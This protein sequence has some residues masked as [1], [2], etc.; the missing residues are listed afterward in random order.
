MEDLSAKLL[1]GLRDNWKI[2]PG[3]LKS[4]CKAQRFG[5]PSQ[6]RLDVR[7]RA[8]T[9]AGGL[10][11]RKHLISLEIF[12]TTVEPEPPAAGGGVRLAVAV[13]TPARGYR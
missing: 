3:R 5:S 8:R 7:W 9:G 12:R 10:A 11:G 4:L 2:L 13:V 1:L 6:M